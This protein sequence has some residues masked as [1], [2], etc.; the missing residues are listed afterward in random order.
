MTAAE[1]DEPKII[2][3]SRIKRISQGSGASPDLVREL[4]KSHQAMQKALKG[5]RGGM[6]KMNMKRMMKRFNP[7]AKT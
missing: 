2:T 6:G 3:A 7:G 1:L 4:L 5:M